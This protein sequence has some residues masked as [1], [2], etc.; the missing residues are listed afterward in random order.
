[1]TVAIA[2]LDNPVFPVDN[3]FCSLVA[4]NFSP[5]VYSR[6][7]CS[8]MDTCLIRTRTFYIP[9]TLCGRNYVMLI[10][11]HKDLSLVNDLYVIITDINILDIQ[12]KV[13]KNSVLKSHFLKK[14]KRSVIFI[15]ILALRW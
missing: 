13:N 3:E 9:A 8:G 14:F 2:S 1:M 6:L 5:Q 10:F 11:T 15:D 12:I 4:G 7:L